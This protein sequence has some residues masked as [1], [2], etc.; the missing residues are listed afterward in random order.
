MAETVTISDDWIPTA[1][2]INALPMPLRVYIH[3]LATHCDPS[4]T[5]QENYELRQQV[6]ALEAMVAM[7]RD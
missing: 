2:N 4:M 5:L 6:R 7:L 1:E 3:K